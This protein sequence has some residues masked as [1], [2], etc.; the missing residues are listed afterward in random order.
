VGNGLNAV[1]WLLVLV[2]HDALIEERI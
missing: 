1:L 2:R